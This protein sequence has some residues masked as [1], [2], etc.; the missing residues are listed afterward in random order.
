MSQK[1]VNS[2]IEESSIATEK[3]ELVK[4]TKWNK[5]T[6]RFDEIKCN[7]QTA[8]ILYN[9]G[10]KDETDEYVLVTCVY[11]N[12]YS[13]VRRVQH[14]CVRVDDMEKKWLDKSVSGWKFNLYIPYAEFIMEHNYPEIAKIFL[15]LYRHVL[16]DKLSKIVILNNKIVDD[17]GVIPYVVRNFEINLKIVKVITLTN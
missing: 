1:N 9:H 12:M 2:G 3:S 6:N 11:T 10:W 8:E 4:L 7:F 14:V 17:K 16:F 13:S 15:D 5:E